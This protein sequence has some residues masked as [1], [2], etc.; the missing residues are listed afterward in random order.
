MTKLKKLIHKIFR[1]SGRDFLPFTYE[2]FYSIRK[3]KILTANNI[4]FLIDV[5]AHDGSYGGKMR[6]YGFAGK[7]VS[8]EPLKNP[9]LDLEKKA[10]MDSLWDCENI[11]IGDSVGESTI[12]VS[13]HLTSSSILAISDKHVEALPTSS[14]IGREVINISTLDTVMKKYNEEDDKILLK[15][16]VQ[17]YE[18][19]VLDGA[20][21]VLKKTKII[22]I[23]L[24]FSEMYKGGIQYMEMLTFLEKLGFTL[25]AINPIF[26]D[27]K[28]GYMLQA[29]GLFINK[30]L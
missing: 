25:I 21:D 1:F 19:P 15:I 26:S 29:D 14:S 5:G 22:E 12:N 4:N 7:M 13:G 9:F 2:Y 17:G 16:D 27:P 3:I 30:K 8:F 24:S 18:K 10:N 23:E 11:A 20:L 6:E 28:T